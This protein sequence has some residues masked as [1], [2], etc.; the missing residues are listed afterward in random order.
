MA[1][2]VLLLIVLSLLF[3]GTFLWLSVSIP[4]IIGFTR[5]VVEWCQSLI[6]MCLPYLHLLRVVFIWSFVFL[7]LAGIV[8]AI[9]NGGMRLARMYRGMRRLPV[10]KRSSNLVL[11]RD[12]SIRIAFTHGLLRPRVYIST[13]LVRYL[14][15]RELKTVVLHELHHK[16]E[17]DPLVFFLLS[18]IRDVFF[19]I[20]VVGSVVEGFIHRRETRA[21]D[22]SLREEGDNLYLARAILKV[23]GTPVSVP[24]FV[25][26][27]AGSVEERVRRLVDGE[28][29][30][31]STTRPMGIVPN[32]L[33]LSF[34][35]IALTLSLLTAP[36]LH[37]CSFQHCSHHVDRIGKDC[38]VHCRDSESLSG[39]DI[40]QEKG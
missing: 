36:S 14:T 13:G 19:Y 26:L 30:K 27:Q 38:V 40:P 12:D 23:S 37:A 6:L 9:V 2:V 24:L 11:I 5:S 16:R 15:P 32:V 4:G 29:K 33:V 10:D 20:P 39:R 1:V 21:D 18:F 7:L 8:Y 28:G 25:A 35:T 31:P 17:K 34:I 22:A 3:G